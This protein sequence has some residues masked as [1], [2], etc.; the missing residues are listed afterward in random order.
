MTASKTPNLGLMS[1]VLSDPFSPD[2]FSETFGILDQH[3][4]VQVIANQASRPTGLGA[5]QHGR[6]YW[7]ADQNIMWVWVQPSAMV[8]GEWQRS[9]CKG[10]L[11]G[12]YNGA[13]VNTTAITVASAPTIVNVN[14][15]VPGGRA[16]MILFKWTFIGNDQARFA[17]TDLMANSS[18]IQE[19]RFNGNGFGPA[20][21]SGTPYPPQ[22][23]Q[24]GYVY[25]GINAQTTMNF[26]LK[27]R[28]Q[29][30]A[31]VGS[32]QGGGSAFIIGTSMDVFE[33]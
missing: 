7:Q 27:L 1:P 16:L 17:T 26:Q 33:L 14:T 29:D 12:A 31:V 6:M 28:C 30:P 10:W 11:G 9:G 25:T 32:Q 23:Q 4:G 13:Q 19:A 18:V 5:A 22:S 2:D 21:T 15:L 8:A 24:H 3:P 20:Y